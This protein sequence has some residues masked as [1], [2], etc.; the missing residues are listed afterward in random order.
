MPY[1]KPCRSGRI[2]TK[3]PITLFGSDATGGVFTEETYTVVLSLHGAGIGSR[4][5]LLA[6]QEL[7]LRSMESNCET[8]IRV[9]GEIG[10]QARLYTYGVAFRDEQLDFWQ[11]EFPPLPAEQLASKSLAL[12]CSGCH[13][14]IT[15]ERGDFE[16]DVC[17]IQGGLVRYCEDCAFATVR[18]F[19]ATSSTADTAAA[20]SQASDFT[21]S[22]PTHLIEPLQSSV[23]VMEGPSIQSPE[24]NVRVLESLA[25]TLRSLPTERR[26]H[27]RAKVNY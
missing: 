20:E 12:E 7:T 1:D 19:P 23:A 6:E 4:H 27:G 16:L 24:A 3:A 9:V 22:K 8:D 13:A 21:P 17:T 25:E 18:K 5:K 14:P 2:S 15:I 11:Q 10:S 26:I